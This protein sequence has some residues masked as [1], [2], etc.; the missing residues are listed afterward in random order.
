MQPLSRAANNLWKCSSCTNRNSTHLALNSFLTV[1]TGLVS[2]TQKAANYWRFKRKPKHAWRR[3][4]R[5]LRKAWRLPRMCNGISN[6]R[7]RKSSQSNRPQAD[8]IFNTD[9]DQCAQCPSGAKV[10][11]TIQNCERTICGR[12]LLSMKA[13]IERYTNNDRQ[14]IGGGT[15]AM[16]YMFIPA[17]LC[18]FALLR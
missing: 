6:G 18:A 5:T 7:R 16:C 11:G 9:D 1:H 3:L 17:N 8:S 10:P 4:E 2:S 13:R 14:G 15:R 12:R